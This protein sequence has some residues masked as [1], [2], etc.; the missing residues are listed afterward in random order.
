MTRL[1]HPGARALFSAAGLFLVLACIHT[2]PLVTDLNGLSRNDN[3][4][5]MLNEW[6]VSWVAHQL[7][8]APTRLFEANIFHP[9]P[10]T[11]A[12]SEPLILPGLNTRSRSSCLA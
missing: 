11:L 2:W 5:T 12:Y 8:R 7:P 1:G 3:A 9:H 6:A 10:H 4:D